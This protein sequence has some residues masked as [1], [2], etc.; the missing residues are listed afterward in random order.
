MFTSKVYEGNLK[1]QRGMVLIVCLIILLM[2]SLIGI[3]SITTSNNDLTVA[4][5][6]MN[7]TGA[8][9]AA[10][11]GLERAASEM[12]TSYEETGAPPNPLPTGSMNLNN[13]RF[14]YRVADDGPA[15]QEIL[16]VGSYSGLYGLVKSFSISSTGFE[17]GRESA[18][19]MAMGIQ[20]ALIPLYQFAVFYEY[21][22][23]M[24]PGPDMTIGGRVHSN[25][26]I[27]VQ[28]ENNLF[29]N[30]HMTSG[31]DIIHGRKAGGGSINNSGNIFITDRDGNL[32]N[33]RNNNGSYLD[34]YDPDWVSSSLSRWGGN[35]EDE[36]HG[37][38]ELYLPVVTDGPATNLIDRGSG[39]PDSYENQAGLKFVDGQVLYR[40]MDGTWINVTGA[41][42]GVISPGVFNDGRE[43]LDVNSLDIDIGALAGTGYY[44]SNGIIYASVP[45]VAGVLTA[46]RLKNGATL[47]SGLTVA[48]NNP[49]YTQGDFNT[50]N[51]KPASL[52]A[53]A[54]TVL[55]NNWNDANSWHGLGTR[56]ATQTQ[57][58]ACMMTGNTETGVDGNGYNGG[59]ENFTRFLEDWTG[60]TY[61]SVGSAADL[62]YSRKAVGAW[63][64]GSYYRS[65]NLSWSF[66]TDL[67]DP[68]KL[69]PGA[70]R[71]NIIQR[72][73]WTQSIINEYHSPYSP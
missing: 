21:D 55:S 3:A 54:I 5:N 47:Q 65:P 44:P 69:P 15:T 37:I 51:K 48:T 41:M 50:V 49:L 57:V 64:T 71:I 46:V 70:P 17:T 35:V 16:D 34:S 52:M 59:F 31:G 60:V 19:E 24:S 53:D 29:V 68:T 6:E 11:A 33:M 12:K 62:W 58:N 28:S 18:V 4:G 1:G 73:S 38:T 56:N 7:Q 42:G 26:N 43:G 20:D 10:E 63:S 27:Y 8:F 61:R 67:L 23:E 13:F 32:Q 2:L 45:D 14:A 30:S 25:A 72:T 9:Y 66:D 39:N 36:N 40:Q 22:L